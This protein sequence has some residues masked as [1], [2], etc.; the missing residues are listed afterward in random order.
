MKTIKKTTAAGVALA[1]TAGLVAGPVMGMSQAWAAPTPGTITIKPNSANGE[2]ANNVT[3][4]AYQI[5][6]A[7][8]EDTEASNVVWADGVTAAA[9]TAILEELGVKAGANGAQAAADAMSKLTVSNPLTPDETMMKI[10]KIVM[11]STDGT[12]NVTPI[13]FNENKAEAASTGYYMIISTTIDKVEDGTPVNS[14]AT[15]PIFTLLT[16]QGVEITEKVSIPTL[17]KQVKEDSTDEFG[18]EADAEFGEKLEFMLSGSLPSNLASFDK[19]EYNF[20]DSF[21]DGIFIIDEA[22]VVVTV[23][24]VDVTQQLPAGAIAITT[25][26]LTVSIED[27]KALDLGMVEVEGEAAKKKVL[28]P[29]DKI[30]VSYKAALNKE[31]ATVGLDKANLN[32]AKIEYTRDPINGGTGFSTPDEAKVYSYSI[33]LKKVDSVS[34]AVIPGTDEDSKATFTFQAVDDNDEVIADRETF[35]VSTDKNGMA[36]VNGL[37]AGKY[38]VK[39]TKAPNG[40]SK[41]EDFYVTVSVTVAGET[42]T[43]A[44]AS[45]SNMTTVLGS[46]VTVKDAPNPI[47]L[48]IT[49]EQGVLALMLLATGLVVASGI[50]FAV[51]RRKGADEE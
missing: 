36:T 24:D 50:G 10:A 49:G 41:V 11:G 44:A 9:Q 15:T 25:T 13:T 21:A 46:E 4:T 12:P 35:T 48:P 27:V 5:F 26:G 1:A 7:N 42:K 29:T 37:D 51:N 22:D 17:T 23:G 19:Y 8:V 6:K 39:E 3:Y 34:E 2:V 20:H 38:L 32:S 16:N 30:V 43:V 33:N 40:Y 31:K 45:D 47:N 28:A 18:K 14:I